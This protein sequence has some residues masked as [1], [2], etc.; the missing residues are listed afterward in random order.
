MKPLAPDYFALFIDMMAAERGASKNTLDAY[1]RDLC[2]CSD[3][4]KTRHPTMADSL[5]SAQRQELESYFSHLVTQSYSP[6]TRAR[7]RVSL[8]QF[9]QFLV[10]ENYR[11]DNPMTLIDS[12]HLGRPLPKI[13]EQSLIEG[14]LTRAEQ[15]AKIAE[16]QQPITK[17]GLKAAA[18]ARRMVLQLELLWGSGLRVSELLTLPLRNL[19]P[20]ERLALVKGKGG[21]ERLIPVTD[22]SLAALSLYLPYRANWFLAA[23]QASNLLFPRPNDTMPQHRSDFWRELKSLSLRANIDPRLVSPHRLRHSCATAML[24]G[25]ANLREVQSMLGH[26]DLATTEIYT[27]LAIDHLQDMLRTHHPLG[28]GLAPKKTLTE[29]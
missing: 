17:P 20:T 2:H 1:L 4:L 8:R 13:L 9:F 3:Y 21:R 25:G 24:T 22:H 14:L 28:A 19:R 7:R 5:A 23:G 29:E 16:S 15:E 27:H 18:R 6:Q 10:T 12:P 26:V 11:Q